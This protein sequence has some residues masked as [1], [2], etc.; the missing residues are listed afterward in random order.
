[1]YFKRRLAAFLIDYI[2]FMPFYFIIMIFTSGDMFFESGVYLTAK[3]EMLQN[4]FLLFI[5]VFFM[6]RDIIKGQSIGKRIAR[7]KVVDNSEKNA[8]WWQLILRNISVIIWP[9][10]A[11]LLLVDKKR[12]GDRM[13]NTKVVLLEK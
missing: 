1:M 11:L 8:A 10:E 5:L 13:A 4:L 12:I 9:L 7:I 6:S 3:M 2:M